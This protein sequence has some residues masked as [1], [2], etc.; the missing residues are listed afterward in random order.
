MKLINFGNLT[1]NKANNQF[2]I[3]L[4]SK[5]LKKLGLTP[6][7]LMDY[8]ILKPKNKFYKKQKGGKI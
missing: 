5:K 1:R 4:R 8:L 7:Q 6:E 2:S 3:N